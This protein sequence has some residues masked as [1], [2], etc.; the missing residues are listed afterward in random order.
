MK[1]EQMWIG[2]PRQDFWA[3][4]YAAVEQKTGQKFAIDR[5]PSKSDYPNSLRIL[6]K[7]KW[8]AYLTPHELYEEWLPVEL[9]KKDATYWLEVEKGEPF[10]TRI[11]EDLDIKLSDFW[12]DEPYW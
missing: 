9:N 5:I 7:E 4:F 1:I 11:L 12:D 2:N 3:R 10:Y 8:V 6:T